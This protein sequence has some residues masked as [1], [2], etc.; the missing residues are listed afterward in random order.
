MTGPSSPVQVFVSAVV[1]QEQVSVLLSQ[2]L[3]LQ[4][5]VEQAWAARPA[6]IQREPVGR[7]LRPQWGPMR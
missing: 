3:S 4:V 5:V 2:Q 6:G 1:P 7:P